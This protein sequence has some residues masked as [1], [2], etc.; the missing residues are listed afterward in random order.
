MRIELFH[1]Q[2][3]WFPPDQPSD[4][5]KLVSHS[6]C[7]GKSGTQPSSLTCFAGILT[8]RPT[9]RDAST[10]DCGLCNIAHMRYQTFHTTRKSCQKRRARPYRQ[11]EPKPHLAIQS[12]ASSV[13]LHCR[14]CM[15]SIRTGGDMGPHGSASSRVSDNTSFTSLHPHITMIYAPKRIRRLAERLANG[16]GPRRK[17]V[18]YSC[19]ESK[20]CTVAKNRLALAG[21]VA[22]DGT[23]ARCR[24]RSQD[25][26]DYRD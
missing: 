13:H 10:G 7:A 18:G 5:H 17:K 26:L 23:G 11:A 3:R 4:P 14:L 8:L 6:S 2:P 21:G 24:L 20:L 16:Y 15:I 22:D 19:C 1:F 25:S 9:L 12:S